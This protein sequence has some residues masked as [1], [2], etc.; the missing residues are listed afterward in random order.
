MFS[1]LDIQQFGLVF[2]FGGRSGPLYHQIATASSS[3]A[4]LNISDMCIIEVFSRVA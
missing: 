4:A 2:G 3:R 1:L